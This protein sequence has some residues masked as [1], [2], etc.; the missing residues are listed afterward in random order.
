MTASLKRQAVGC[1]P[2]PG[3]CAWEGKIQA[4]EVEFLAAGSSMILSGSVTKGLL[5]YVPQVREPQTLHV[6]HFRKYVASF[7]QIFMNILPSEES[8]WPVPSCAFFFL[9]MCAFVQELGHV[10]VPP[11]DHAFCLRNP[12]PFFLYYEKIRQPIG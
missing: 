12:I 5:A 11:S 9:H 8:P 10:Q 3:P 2:A 4:Q 7:H 1:L 6:Y